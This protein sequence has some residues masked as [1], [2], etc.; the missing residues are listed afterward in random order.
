MLCSSHLK[1]KEAVT[2]QNTRHHQ[3]IRGFN[4]TSHAVAGI[5]AWSV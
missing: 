5:A 2:L 3:A 4:G 1:A